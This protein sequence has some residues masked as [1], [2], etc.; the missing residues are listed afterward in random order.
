MS[1]P[2]DECVAHFSNSIQC[3]KRYGTL[4]YF[5]SL[6]NILAIFSASASLANLQ[7]SSGRTSIEDGG[8]ASKDGASMELELPPAEKKVLS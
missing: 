7:D 8:Q 5:C 1:E 6:D 3:T 4:P 2:L